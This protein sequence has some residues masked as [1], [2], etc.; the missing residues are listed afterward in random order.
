MNI[1]SVL[2]IAIVAAVIVAKI[3]GR[4]RESQ[5]QGRRMVVLP[6]VLI[7]VGATS[8]ASHGKGRAAMHLTHTDLS[9]LV[10]GIVVSLLMG[11][12]RGATIELTARDGALFQRYRGVTVGLWFATIAVRLGMDA[13]GHGVGAASSVTSRAL[14][15]MF[16]V[17]LAGEALAVLGRAA[18]KGMPLPS[19]ERG[20]G[21]IADRRAKGDFAN[22]S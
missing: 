6:A 12:A 2:E 3:V 8:I 7:V 21:R 22:W 15:L 5:V 18:M 11:V 14:L 17:S 20:A 13:I 1:S 9:F 4:M 19:M 16:G 10:I